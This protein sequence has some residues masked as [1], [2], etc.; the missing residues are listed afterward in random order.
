MSGQGL[1]PQE[2]QSPDSSLQEKQSLQQ[3]QRRSE[4]LPQPWQD[5][6]RSLSPQEQSRQVES[7][8]KNKQTYFV[9]P[10]NIHNQNYIFGHL[11]GANLNQ[12]A[13]GQHMFPEQR[14]NIEPQN[15]FQ[16][17]HNQRMQNLQLHDASNS[18]HQ[19]VQETNN[20]Q[21]FTPQIPQDSAPRLNT[22]QHIPHV[23]SQQQQKAGSQPQQRKQHISQNLQHAQGIY[24]QQHKVDSDQ[25]ASN[26]WKQPF[27]KQQP[28]DRL[29]QLSSFQQHQGKK[30]QQQRRWDQQRDIK[31]NN[32][33][34]HRRD[35]DQQSVQASNQRP[36]MKQ[37]PQNR[38]QKSVTQSHPQHQIP[39]SLQQQQQSSSFQQHQR[40]KDQQQR[41]WDQQRDIRDN[42]MQ[43]HRRDLDQQSVQASNQR[44]FMK[45]QPQNR[46]QKSATQSHP[47]HQIPQSLQQQQQSSSFQQHQRKKDQQQRRWDQQRDIKDN[48]MQQH[49]RDLDQQSVQASNQRPFMK[50]QPQNRLQK[51]VTQSHPQHQIPQSLQQ[52]QQSSSFQQHQRKKD[53]QQQQITPDT[54]ATLSKLTLKETQELDMASSTMKNCQ[55]RIPRRQRIKQP[56][57]ETASIKVNTNMFKIKFDNDFLKKAVHYDVDITIKQPNKS[58][59]QTT[60]NKFSKALCRKI[61]EQCRS[62]NFSKRYPAFD[63]KK[64][65]YSAYDLPFESPKIFETNDISPCNK[66][67]PAECNRHSRTFIVILKK[68]A[69]VDLSWTRNLPSSLDEVDGYQTGIQ[70]LDIIMRHGPESQYIN[71]GGSFFWQDGLYEKDFELS[72]ELRAARGGFLSVIL[73]QQMYLNVDVVHKAFVIPQEVGPLYDRY[74]NDTINKLLKDLKVTYQIPE[75]NQRSYRLDGLGSTPDEQTFVYGTK[76]I[77]VTNYFAK[78]YK[79]NL[80]QP[81]WQ[82]LVVKGQPTYLP[83]ELCTIVSGQSVKKLNNVQTSKMIK[84]AAMSAPDRKKEIEKSKGVFDKLVENNSNI[85]LHEFQLSVENKMEKVNARILNAPNIIYA[86][87]IVKVIKGTWQMQKFMQPINLEKNQWTILCIKDNN[88]RNSK[89]DM[90]IYTKMDQFM[91]KLKDYAD[92]VGMPI[93]N[94]NTRPFKCFDSEEIAKIKNYFQQN[95]KLKLI[96]V[97][98]PNSSGTIYNKI[99]QITELELGVLTQCIKLSNFNNVFENPKRERSIIKNILLKINTKLNGINHAL[100]TRPKCFEKICMFVG[101]DVTHP[102]YDEDKPSIAAVTASNDIDGFQ[103]NV[104][105]KVLPSKQEIILDFK[106]IIDVQLSIYKD[107]TSRLPERIIY[108][109]DGVSE[110]QLPQVMHYEI[111]GIRDAY[112]NKYKSDIEITCLIVQKRHHVRLFPT[113]SKDTDDRNGNVKAGTIVDSEITHPNHF[114][115]YL[116]S[117]ASIQGTARP[118]K[119][120]CICNDSNFTENEMEKLTYYLCHMYARCTRTVSYPVPTYYAHLAAYRGKVLLHGYSDNND[121]LNEIQERFNTK[122]ANLPMY[123]V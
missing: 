117:H 13:S 8:E 44:P 36:F 84:I 15:R 37:Q 11:Q 116:V 50:Q 120:K 5:E 76:E 6:A 123:F 87:T 85:M 101:A 33:Q 113:S 103:Y 79:Y 102:S 94:A 17:Q 10:Q 28:Q 106:N 72:D 42:N 39:Q 122:M 24:F 4:N 109:R 61:F 71:V 16:S 60:S 47:Q 58:S 75:H 118:T 112:K 31:D 7:F 3:Q 88:D 99:K 69:E 66:R 96:I 81:T 108:Y 2:E 65:A 48:N 49:R 62:K 45:Q 59:T 82:C 12:Q 74:K 92:D 86:N 54:L 1:P 73:G 70:V 30:N 104:I 80:K 34:Q 105:H 41:R 97:I 40:K 114:D 53:Q 110:G 46:L 63:G 14:Y 20:K 29:Q 9:N 51:S 55:A 111:G 98:I 121:K 90:N 32:M 78:R 38:L 35:L 100:D 77:T 119:Y 26:Q 19:L 22:P 56:S 57:S 27:R 43:Q 23:L 83:P 89:E 95:K 21:I 107:K 52:Q 93:E 67:C 64:N 68:V 18:D 25:Q 91:K 115:F